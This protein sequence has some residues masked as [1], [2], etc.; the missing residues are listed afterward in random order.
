ML[1]YKTELPCTTSGQETERVYSYNPRTRT[2]RM[3]Q[4]WVRHHKGEF[5][6]RGK[7]MGENE[8]TNY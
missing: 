8:M 3:P 4:W 6:P 5:W 2:E 7:G 1:K